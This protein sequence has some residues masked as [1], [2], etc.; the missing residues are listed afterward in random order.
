MSIRLQDRLVRVI[1]G[2]PMKPAASKPG[3][4][5]TRPR[6][7]VS[8]FGPFGG[9]EDNASRLALVELRKRL[10]W[11][12]TRVLPVDSVEAP[13]RLRRAMAVIRP[14]LVLMLGE[15]AGSSVVRLEATA[16]NLLDF[17][18]PDQSGRQP[19]QRPIERG[20]S[21]EMPSVLPLES[22]REHLCGL[23][24]GVEISSDPGRYL[25]NQVYY[26]TRR[27]TDKC[28]F[29][30]LPLESDLPTGRAVVLLE[31]L[32]RCLVAWVLPSDGGASTVLQTPRRAKL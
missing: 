24:H 17:R 3:P 10:P 7:L 11:I 22:L 6:V 26:V 5:G 16:W 1:S 19:R 25:C 29:V 4:P 15:A 32:L 12:R 2:G 28:L 14:E 20:A 21:G 9:R 18:I 8:A 27:L 23:G 30:H 13:A 31:E